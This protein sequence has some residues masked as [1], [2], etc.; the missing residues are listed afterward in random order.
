MHICKL[1]PVISA[2]ISEPR[3]F[4]FTAA[5][6]QIKNSEVADLLLYLK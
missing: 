3:M 5:I 4:C 1:E 6:M 2:E